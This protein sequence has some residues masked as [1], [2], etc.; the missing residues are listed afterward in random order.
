MKLQIP[1][2]I[3]PSSTNG[4]VLT[5]VSGRTAWAT[6]AA[7]GSAGGGGSSDSTLRGFRSGYSASGNSVSVAV[8]SEA[9]V[10]DLLV[11]FVGANNSIAAP[12]NGWTLAAAST[13]S[14]HNSSVLM[15]V[16]AA[17]DIGATVT[18]TQDNAATEQVDWYCLAF[19][20]G[21]SRVNVVGT[22]QVGPGGTG[23]HYV[24]TGAVATGSPGSL[25]Y[26]FGSSR[27]SSGA[28]SPSAS[29]VTFTAVATRSADASARSGVWQ[30]SP[31]IPQSGVRLNSSTG[32][33][34][35]S[36][37]WVSID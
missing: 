19:G 37:G 1:K 33:P 12:Q 15:K 13:G 21:K 30:A 10:G 8:P 27:V 23:A 7:G 6:P 3:K 5:T 29:G 36:C 14:W 34:G 24:T 35:M 20:G 32:A 25:L 31:G 17:E 9:Q 26:V 28:V 18:F 4:D 16:C 11:L 22:S 2:F